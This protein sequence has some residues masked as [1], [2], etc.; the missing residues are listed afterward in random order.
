MLT[1]YFEGVVRPAAPDLDVADDEVVEA[2]WFEPPPDALHE[3]CADWVR[4]TLGEDSD[5]TASTVA[6]D[7]A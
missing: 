1:V 5:G 7:D 3:H 6:H 2:R 4:E